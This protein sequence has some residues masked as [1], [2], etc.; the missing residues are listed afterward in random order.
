MIA[1]AEGNNDYRQQ[2]GGRACLCASPLVSVVVLGS[3]RIGQHVCGDSPM[4]SA[5]HLL[6]SHAA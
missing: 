1:S 2:Y 3:M 6:I 4:L 5:S